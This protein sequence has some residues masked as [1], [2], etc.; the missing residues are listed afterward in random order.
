MDGAAVVEK[1]KFASFIERIASE[2]SVVTPVPRG[3]G[4][5]S[6]AEV[7]DASSLQN[8]SYRPTLNSP[9][10][11][12]LP[13]QEVLFRFTG[14]SGTSVRG[15]EEVQY[16]QDIESPRR[17]LLAVRPCDLAAIQRMDEVF[18]AAEPDHHYL[19][20]RQRSIIIGLDCPEP[21]DEFA[22]C[23]AMG[24]S[25]VDEGFD[26]LLVDLDDVWYVR[27]GTKRGEEFLAECPGVR[28]AGGD[29]V[30]EVQ[31]VQKAKERAFE[32]CAQDLPVPRE[33]LPELLR[34]AEESPVWEEYGERCLGCGRCNLVCPTCFCF[35][36]EDIVAL[37]LGKGERRRRWDACTLLEFAA[38]AGG[39]NFR[40]D[41]ADR[42][43]HMFQH[44][45][46][47]APERYG[48][49]FCTG[50]GRCARTCLAGIIPTEVYGA[51]REDVKDGVD[52]T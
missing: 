2:V 30:R 19:Q 28:A 6:F 46:R 3:S 10:K 42:L 23:A 34:R 15:G 33:D 43:R 51:L 27:I 31:R 37:D 39:E 48:E 9:K 25:E 16:E 41:R 4:E 17:V 24:T 32:R 18:R 52:E 21:C 38:V 49:L 13:P 45:G 26:L 35:D 5:F 36:V 8:P 50:C 20:R 14:K 47:Y 12:F 11:Y 1:C 40:R 7:Q 29:D 22:F 44:K